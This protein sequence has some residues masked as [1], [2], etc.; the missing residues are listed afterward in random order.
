MYRVVFMG[1]PDFA[2]PSLLALLEIADVVG[3]VTQPDRPAGRGRSLRPSPVKVAAEAAGVAV[4]QPASLRREEAAEPLRAWQPDV[5]VVAAFGQI[6]RPHVLSLPPH[7]CVNVHASLLPRWRGAS[8]I[9]HAILAGDAESGV[10]LMQMERGLDTGPVFV[11]EAIPLL[12]T[13]TATTLHDKLAALGADMMRR[14][15]VDIV[16][17][18]LSP[19]PQDGALST[20]AP[21]IVKENGRLDW[22]DSSQQLDR[23]LRAMNPWPG[24]FT[25]WQGELFKVVAAVPV[26]GEE[27]TAVPGQVLAGGIVQ[28]G[29]GQI[30]LQQVQPAGK[31]V[32]NIDDFLRG[33]PHFVGEILG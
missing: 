25:S 28:T 18:R 3:V 20:Y 8:P 24:A 22:H 27:E 31:R 4:Y 32:M 13:E 2:V 15:L 16:N 14:H 33:N 12:P 11:Q 23:Q 1:T 21:M 5:I 9:Q 19:T 29:S 30:A 17:G 7:G 10:S 26:I 6:L